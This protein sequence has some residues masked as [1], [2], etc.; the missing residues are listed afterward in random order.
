[1]ELYK[2]SSISK[3]VPPPLFPQSPIPKSAFTLYPFHKAGLEARLATTLVH[4]R[5]YLDTT[6]DPWASCPLEA[7]APVV[8]EDKN[9]QGQGKG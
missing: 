9:Q 3:K 1:M 8:K 2:G 6:R 4:L 7:S 5:E